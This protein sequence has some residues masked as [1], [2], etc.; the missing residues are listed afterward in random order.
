MSYQYIR[1]FADVGIDDVDIVGGKNAS[2]G[3][4]YSELS[5]EGVNIPNGF[6]TTADAYRYFL[7]HNDLEAK[8]TEALSTLDVEDT[9]ALAKTGEYIRTLIVN[10][11]MPQDVVDEIDQAYKQ[12]EAEYG[13]NVDVAVRSSATAEDLP[14]ASFAGQQESHLN[15]TGTA[16]LL[17]SCRQIFASLFT[18]RAISYRVHQGFDHMSVALA[19]AVQKMVRSDKASSGVMFSI[20]TESGFR[21]IVFITGAWGL[22]ENVVQGAVNP[23]EFYVFKPTLGTKYQPIIKHNLGSKALRMVYAEKGSAI[24]DTGAVINT[25]VPLEMQNQFCINDDEVLELAK[26]AVIIEKH[27]TKKAGRPMPM[28]IEWAKDG[29]SGELFVVQARPETVESGK[30]L[31]ALENHVLEKKGKVIIEGKSVGSKVASGKARV[32]LKTSQMADLKPGEILVTDITDPD[33]EPVMKIAGAIV[34]NRGGRTCHAAIIARELGI[35]AIVSTN[36]AT[37][38]I[39]TGDIVTVSCAEGDTGTV[40]QGALPHHV[41]SIDISTIPVPKNTGIMLNLANPEIAFKT[42]NLPNSGV[43]LARMEF[44]INNSIGVHPNALIDYDDLTKT[45]QKK[46]A[47]RMA[48]YPNPISFYVHKLAEGIATIASAFYPKPVI[49]RLSDFKSNE[50][51]NLIGGPLYEPEEENPMLG[52]RGATRYLSKSFSEAF[53]LECNALR[54]ARTTMGLDN[55]T[56]MIPFARTVAETKQVIELMASHGLVRGKRGLKIYLM[57]ELPANVILADQ[58]L[59]LVDGFSIGSNDLTQLTLGADRDSSLL[60]HYDERNEAVLK[61]IEMAIAA[62]KKA[63]KYVGICGQ[64]PSDFPE[65]TKFLVEQGVSTVSVNPDSVVEMAHVI[66]EMEDK[67]T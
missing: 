27:Y 46:I 7:K 6:A 37:K 26:T 38:V 50:Y 62:C 16:A 30:S 55:I 63:G 45:L 40:Y 17:N 28:D 1:F 52:F 14:D 5:R 12:L 39:K 54:I 32:I 31:Q 21:D 51:A 22:G 58:F 67:L 2:L 9:N 8:I 48:G 33:W 42:S 65:I 60:G 56:V 29:D 57:C 34:T 41:Q 23:D 64:A 18:N 15:I 20:D 13:K 61:L 53:A 10:G 24:G 35:A 25:D 4:M 43:G 47:P 3:E 11:V 19:I 44:I 59:E 36:T 49:V 66:A